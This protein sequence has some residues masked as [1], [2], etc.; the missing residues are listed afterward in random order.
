M[1]SLFQTRFLIAAASLAL[2]PLSQAQPQTDF[3]R[4][5]TQLATAK[6]TDAER[7]HA[8][9]KLDWE[10]TLRDNPERATDVGFPGLNDR[11]SDVSVEAVE[12][13]KRELQS[14]LKV[15]KSIKRDKLGAEDQ[16]NFDLFKYDLDQSIAGLKFPAELMPLTQ[17]NG[18]QQ[19]VA[20][21]LQ[22]APRNM[23]KDYEDMI[24][25]LKAVPTLIEQNLVLLRKGLAAGITPPA[26]TLRD[27]PQ[28]VTNQ[29]EADP[30]KNALLG[31]F[32]EFPPEISEAD[33]L[34]L[35]AA[36][37]SAVKERV[38]PAY[39]KLHD[40]LVK[41]Y[42]PGAR[43]SIA[44]S[45]LPDGK[46]W[47]AHNVRVSTTTAMTPEQIHELG[48]S[49]VK[50]IRGEMDHVIAESGFKGGFNEFLVFLRTDPRFYYTNAADLLRGYRDICKRI[51][52]ELAHMFGRLP[53]LTYGVAQVPSYAEKS[54][55]TAYYQPGAPNAGRAGL[56]YANTFALNT[57]PIWEM[58]AL[59]L[60]ESV[61]GHHFQIALAQE[62][63]DVPEF[64]KHGGHTAFVEG[65]GLYAESL[66]YEMGFY[67][68]PYAKFGQLV[69]EMWRAIRLVVD[70][71]MHTKGWTRQQA[72]DYFLA[73]AAKNE[74]DV[75]VEV[76]RYIVW[77]GQALAYKI[78]QLKIRE[79]RTYATKELGAKFDVRAFHDQVLDTGSLPLATLEERIK[80]WVVERKAVK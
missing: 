8:L 28:Q 30:A 21:T 34:R 55:T 37:A 76:D 52:P 2:V 45:E 13:R 60:H 51:D 40:F 16:L 33:R 32:K 18:V 3:E 22:L 41:E 53:R 56:Y 46:A 57:R 74:H 63:A 15:M 39:G 23:V 77:P 27:V 38:I 24:A 73:N 6:Q 9:F 72:I 66:G 78:G 67:K 80:A 61:P 20:Q 25:R 12:R 42:L 35:R 71:G 59:S 54:Q 17:L 58:E 5:C 11:W 65:W 31:L 10:H 19:D 36:A 29:M 26:I 7:L 4:A 64:R 68:D 75:T 79:L 43:A 48:L 69:Y 62:M 1:I 44:L 47:Y 14:P 50:R 49:E 70:T